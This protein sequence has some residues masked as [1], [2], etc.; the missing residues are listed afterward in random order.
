LPA[1]GLT[2]T[3]PQKPVRIVTSGVGGAGDVASRIIAHGI[4]P[5]LGQQVIVDNRASGTI[6]VETVV[7][8][9]ADGYTLLL[10]GSTV[11]LGPFLRANVPYDPLKDLAP[12]TLAVT[13]PN[14]LI[15]H[16]SL[17]ARS[18]KEL[19]ALARAKPGAVNY[20]A[21]GI[22]SSPHLA[23][24]LFKAMAKVDLTRISYKGAGAALT[25]V[26]AGQVQMSFATG[27]SATPHVT[28]GRL[29]ALAVTS[30]QPSALF[31]KLP[32][33]AASGV[34]GYESS[35]TTGI[36]MRA[37]TPAAMQ[38]R[39]TDELLRY[40]RTQDAKDKFL[41]TG[42]EV[43]AGTPEQLAARMRSEMDRL[44]KIIREAGITGDS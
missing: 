40:L 38:S 8:A 43:V 6:P 28:S 19:I 4:T 11:W 32:T 16:P 13:S 1:P 21:T 10:Y 37:G 22:G 30:A 42:V 31:P 34:P 18:V 7:R 14:V 9:P 33:I 2:Q 41:S 24:E 23:G 15:V 29:R 12:L 26:M 5:S 36:F 39:M 27:S 44:G 35:S 3:Y 20:A 25:E 17:P